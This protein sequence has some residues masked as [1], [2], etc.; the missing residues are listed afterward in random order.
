MDQDDPVGEPEVEVTDLNTNR[1]VKFHAKWS[2]SLQHV[3]DQA[4]IELKEKRRQRDELECADGKPLT[5]FL[6]QTLEQLRKQ[7]ICPGRKYQIKGETGG[8]HAA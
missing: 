5:Q 4:Y 7:H 8:A 1:K 2:D 6:A 3:W